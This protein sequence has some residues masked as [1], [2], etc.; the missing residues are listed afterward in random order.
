[1]YL[2]N[3][4]ICTSSLCPDA[5][6]SCFLIPI[7][8]ITVHFRSCSRIFDYRKITPSKS[9]LMLHWFMRVTGV[10]LGMMA[11]WAIK[12]LSFYNIKLVAWF[13]IIWCE[14]GHDDNL[15]DYIFSQLELVAWFMMYLNEGRMEHCRFFLFFLKKRALSP[16]SIIRK[17][18]CR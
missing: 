5:V 13:V 4:H 10:R 6:S 16:I 12:V 3:R 18:H 9:C 14:I 7:R 15:C 17:E 1:M 8:T 2:C 11:I